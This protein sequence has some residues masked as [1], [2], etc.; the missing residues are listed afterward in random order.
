MILKE[1]FIYFLRLG[2]FGFGGPFAIVASIQN[3]L[4]KERKWVSEQEFNSAFSL[5]K[6]M[7]GP[8]AFMT[9]VFIGRYRGGLMGGLLAAIGLV[10]P[11]S[12]LMIIFSIFFSTIAHLSFTTVLLLGMQVCALGVI[13]G[14]LKNLIQKNISH[15]LFW[16]LVIISGMI[17]YSHPKLEPF[18]IISF[19]LLVM[20]IKNISGKKKLFEA[21][22]LFALWLVCFKAGA[23]VFGSGLAIVP[24]LKYD[25]VTKY[26]WL[27][28]SEFLDALAF[29]Q[30]T[31]GPVVI[32]STYIGHKVAGGVGALIATVGIFS[33]SF[34]H[35]MTWFPYL[36]KK[37]AGAAW[38]ENFIFGAVAA[39]IGPI[40]VTVWKLFYGLT[41]TPVTMVFLILSLVVTLSGR[42]PMWL[43]IPGGGIIFLAL[44][45][46]IGQ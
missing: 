39:V 30:M 17:N 26:H 22:V 43:I 9:S 16:C 35:I 18:I 41:I 5:I 38:I 8:V 25:V 34:F 31:P 40:I 15:P 19:G 37:L 7:P 6:A 2:T 11:S 27:S 14:S 10:F 44:T 24:M 46:I 4:V 36:I 45:S 29:G 1:I 32:T 13:L 28:E 3:D 42:I 23:L 33:A 21:S 12:I 20:L